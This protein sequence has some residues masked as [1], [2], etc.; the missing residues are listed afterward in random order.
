M[1]RGGGGFTVHRRDSDG[2]DSFGGAVKS[3]G[4]DVQGDMR[5]EEHSMIKIRHGVSKCYWRRSE[6]SRVGQNS[7]QGFEH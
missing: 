1:N 2:H 4:T 3:E 5:Q 7:V 6:R